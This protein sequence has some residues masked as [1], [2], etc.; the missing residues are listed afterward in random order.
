MFRMRVIVVLP[1][2]PGDGLEL[3]GG[4]AF[5][6]RQFRAPSWICGLRRRSWLSRYVVD[7]MVPEEGIEREGRGEKR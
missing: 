4:V 7:S 2:E 3:G 6:S 1:C 5:P